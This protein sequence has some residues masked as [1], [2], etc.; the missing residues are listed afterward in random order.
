MVVRG[1]LSSIADRTGGV[2]SVVSGD[3]LVG[4]T[5]VFL[6]FAVRTPTI[7]VFFYF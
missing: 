5:L 1:V 2:C 7:I 6:F 3:E 4:C